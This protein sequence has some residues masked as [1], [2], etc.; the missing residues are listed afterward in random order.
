MNYNLKNKQI[1]FFGI[2]LALSVFAA[3]SISASAHSARNG[4]HL[5]IAELQTQA[6]KFID[7]R[8]K[9]LTFLLARETSRDASGIKGTNDTIAGLTALKGTISAE[10]TASA[11]RKDEAGM[12]IGTG[13]GATIKNTPQSAL[14]AFLLA[15]NLKM[16]GNRIISISPPPPPPAITEPP[17]PA[18]NPPTTDNE[19]AV[20]GTAASSPSSDAD[21]TTTSASADGSTIVPSP[22]AASPD[23]AATSGA[24]TTSDSGDNSSAVTIPSPAPAGD[25]SSGSTVSSPP[26][27]DPTSADTDSTTSAITPQSTTIDQNTTA[28]TGGTAVTV[29]PTSTGENLGSTAF[30]SRM[31]PTTGF[32]LAAALI[33][34]VLALM[35]RGLYTRQ[36]RRMFASMTALCMVIALSSTAVSYANLS[37]I[38]NINEWAVDGPVS[39]I[40]NSPD[41]I[42]YV[43]GGF[44]RAGIS[45]GT[46]V[47]ISTTTGHPV[48]VY[49]KELTNP[50]IL[51]AVPDHAGGW[52]LGGQF[53]SFGGVPYNRLL[54]IKPD[55]TL[56]PA[57]DPAV[58]GSAVMS[59]ALSPDG[60]TLYASGDFTHVNTD[61]TPV[62]RNNIAA[63]NATTGVVTS[64]N[65]GL[66]I[67]SDTMA[68]T[69]DGG[70]LYLGDNGGIAAINTTTGIPTA[71]DASVPNGGGLQMILS[72]DNSTLYVCGDFS[73]VNTDTTPVARNQ[74][75]AFN[76]TTG[77]AT[78]FDPEPNDVVA[79]IVI[80]PD[81]NTLYMG[82]VF[83]AVNVTTTPV[84]RY[85]TAAINTTTSVATSWD[86]ASDSII[87]VPYTTNLAI[88]PDGKTLYMGGFFNHLNTSTTPVSRFCL[89]AVS[90]ATGIATSWDPEPDSY[91]NVL[92][93]STDGS[94]IYD[95]GF[96]MQLI[97]SVQR[98]GLAAFSNITDKITS[99]DPE[100]DTPA[101]NALALSPDR[102]TLYVG[103]AF[104]N[105]NMTTTPLARNYLAAVSTATGTAT[106]FDPEPDNAINALALSPDESTLYF[107][108]QFANV[109]NLTTP[110]ARNYLA[111]VSTATGTAT[112]FD[113]EPDNIVFSTALS[114]DASTLYFGG[115]FANINTTTTPV[116]RANIAAAETSAGVATSFNPAA[117]NAVEALTLNSSGSTLYAGGLFANIGGAVR[118][119][120]AGLS[121]TTGLATSFDPEPDNSV[122]AL[123]LSP[124][125][126]TLYLAGTFSNINALTTP[127]ARHDLASVDT[128]TG[129]ATSFDTGLNSYYG[130]PPQSAVALS[131]AGH[132]VYAGGYF[133]T[134]A[135]DMYG[136]SFFVRYDNEDIPP[137]AP[138]NLGPTDLTDGSTTTNGQPVFTWTMNDPDISDTLG[139]EIQ[140]STH[141]DYSSPVVDYTSVLTGAQGGAT[142]T[143]GQALLGGSYAAGSAGQS[144]SS[145]TYYWRVQ[146]I[147]QDSAASGY[148]AARFFVFGPAF[149][150]S[151]TPPPAPVISAIVA[152]PSASASAIAWTTDISASSIVDY[153][154]STSYGM[155]TPETDTS[156]RVTAHTISL[157]GLA[158]C[159]LYHFDVKS[160]SAALATSTSGDNTFRTTGCPVAGT[161]GTTGGTSGRMPPPSNYC[162]NIPGSTSMPPGMEF[163]PA[164]DGNCIP[165]PTVQQ[166]CEQLGDCPTGS[167]TGTTTASTS[168][169]TSAGGG[170]TT[171][172]GGSQTTTG[173]TTTGTTAGTTT[174]NGTTAGTTTA[175]SSS[176]TGDGTTI[177]EAPGTPPDA[178]GILTAS[179]GN[180]SSIF[181]DPRYDVGIKTIVLAGLLLGIM[182]TI[183]T[184]VFGTPYSL[185]ELVLI[186]ARL[187]SFLMG[188]LGFQKRT[189]RW[190]TIYDSITKQ[191]LDPVHVSLI[192]AEGA[193][194]GTQITDLDGR[195]GFLV[196]PGHYMLRPEK[197]NYVFPS[198]RLGRVTKD[199]IYSDIYFGNY[200]EIKSEG[201]VI[202]KNIP[203]DPTN[204][205]WNE[206]AK[207]EQELMKFYS[208]RNLIF[209]RVADF[210]FDVGFII[211][212]LALIFAPRPY[213]II[214]F[215]SYSVLFAVKEFG[216]NYSKLGEIVDGKT[217][218]PVPF[219]IMRVFSYA[220]ETEV[221]HKISTEQGLFYCLVANGEYYV[222]I[223]KKNPDGTYAHVFKSDKLVVNKG[224]VK[225]VWKV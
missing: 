103:G 22:T 216:I 185:P 194:V 105:M 59:L 183:A 173:T 120:L 161:T 90:T 170:S 147:D 56:D 224:I 81:G 19:N 23:T 75:A 124:D 31:T 221:T 98:N 146:A 7:S 93:V 52:Y 95:S 205:D 142:F 179:L 28:D 67:Y 189:R 162:A 131:N 61:T 133:S 50:G 207:K 45:S 176:S 212:I 206:V 149:T 214:I 192:D 157:S 84:S 63:F 78:S 9:S 91:P 35:S 15:R 112:N 160:T 152:A 104:N 32:F 27:S 110:L 186:P 114:P 66:G 222:T 181:N 119:Y 102:Q 115:Q 71:F 107:G 191:P 47:P 111:A 99:W 218:A 220:L 85:G 92:S 217:G 202:A 29:L 79:T 175:S 6:D 177:S 203:M 151:I 148:T 215:I 14:Q 168:G 109:N 182:G 2:I 89:G 113:P 11:I 204:F 108:G 122:Q 48:S 33:M 1:F 153:G 126:S 55:G 62:A 159:T 101:V 42:T 167:T 136:Q 145:G 211:A 39:A 34:A 38:P 200:F 76:A 82:G 51:A 54:H 106:S 41:G 69:S 156:P 118:G 171:G 163:D 198:V 26:T 144:L 150:A 121:T 88:S 13:A 174:T 155:T 209:V 17:P 100:P 125:E 195:Y 213:N 129:I 135:N 77:V 210:C 58:D 24:G 166:T 169:T 139:Y 137:N 190:G 74:V 116:A 172:N 16:V 127:V 80:S 21:G 187:W 196:E 193:T 43:G 40:V 138:F 184:M 201:E 5:S 165:I 128:A 199:E 143:V 10:T 134:Q 197:T 64:F 219:A 25:S 117:D 72:P 140:I 180:I 223:E 60:A 96:Y 83:T 164:G 94:T 158:A 44:P 86:P 68:L 8:I 20:P 49:P 132:I 225:G 123:A 4:H 141:A 154:L 73:T 18:V 30:F 12:F 65:P 178:G 53:T 97:N 130:E 208:R 36:R 57:F 87:S 46:S 3:S 70:T 188:W 37:S